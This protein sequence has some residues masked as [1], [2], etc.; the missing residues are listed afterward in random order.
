MMI[1]KQLKTKLQS[2]NGASLMVALLFFVMCA[3]VGSIILAAASAS[4]GRISKV[5]TL[6]N[7]QRYALI[8]ASQ[9]IESDM[10]D[11][12]SMTFPQ[13]NWALRTYRIDTALADTDEDDEDENDAEDAADSKGS[14]GRGNGNHNWIIS[15]DTSKAGG[16]YILPVD[17]TEVPVDDETYYHYDGLKDLSYA[18]NQD[19]IYEDSI[20]DTEIDGSK[21]TN[22]FSDVRQILAD[23]VYRHYWNQIAQ[24]TDE[25]GGDNFWS[26]D[27]D[28]TSVKW[29]SIAKSEPYQVG[30]DGLRITLDEQENNRLVP[31]YMD[32]TMDQDFK[33][34]A[35]LYPGTEDS[36]DKTA[37][38]FA[39][40]RD[41]ALI[42]LYLTVPGDGTIIYGESQTEKSWEMD[43][44]DDDNDDNDDDNDQDDDDDTEEKEYLVITDTSRQV[45]M[46]LNWQKCSISTLSS[47]IADNKESE[48]VG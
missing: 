5:D 13:Q 23:K 3:S 45:S 28:G 2:E 48:N 31:V 18:W 47:E 24:G 15:G 14:A 36:T 6:A 27:I 20:S 40:L 12:A 39:S 21:L 17:L 43:D 4:A 42:T 44:N 26:S 22:G 32:I 16:N 25:E 7:R 1:S 34:T 38:D 9:L 11:S 8:S 30:M 46:T 19:P 41:H 33:I 29:S 35:R 10:N 37:P